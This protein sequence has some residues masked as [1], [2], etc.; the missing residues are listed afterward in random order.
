MPKSAIG[1]QAARWECGR[2]VDGGI[3]A[4]VNH[5]FERLEHHRRPWPLLLETVSKNAYVAES[6]LSMVQAWGAVLSLIGSMG[7]RGSRGNQVGRPVPG[8]SGDTGMLRSLRPR[9]KSCVTAWF[10]GSAWCWRTLRR[11]IMNHERK[12]TWSSQD[13]FPSRSR[14]PMPLFS[15]SLPDILFPTSARQPLRP[16]HLPNKQHTFTSRSPVVVPSLWFPCRPKLPPGDARCSCG[17]PLPVRAAPA[18]HLRGMAGVALSLGVGDTKWREG[19]L[20]T[21]WVGQSVVWASLQS[22]ARWWTAP[23]QTDSD[24]TSA[25]RTSRLTHPPPTRPCRQLP[26][27][28]VL[29][30]CTVAQD[31]R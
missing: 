20:P 9:S 24:I 28:A 26:S 17:A 23:V 30:T 14:V 29:S 10:Q 15:G 27:S 11:L 12:K 13:I 16:G 18:S 6:P 7:L 25:P 2:R 31:T 1:R 22:I 21:V 19:Q 4:V 5:Q 3:R 8:K